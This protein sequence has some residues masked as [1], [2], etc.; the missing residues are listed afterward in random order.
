MII[1]DNAGVI[2]VNGAPVRPPFQVAQGVKIDY[3]LLTPTLIVENMFE[4]SFS[5]SAKLRFTSDDY[6]NADNRSLCIQKKTIPNK[7]FD[8]RWDLAPKGIF[9]LPIIPAHNY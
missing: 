9:L 6:H 1:F 8:P 3:K 7:E 5:G 2:T 4:L